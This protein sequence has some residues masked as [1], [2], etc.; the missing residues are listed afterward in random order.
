ML[1][2]I[3]IINISARFFDRMD[4]MHRMS[5][6]EELAAWKRMHRTF[7]PRSGFIL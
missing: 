6:T 3:L 2:T 4:G 5:G 7:R 1:A